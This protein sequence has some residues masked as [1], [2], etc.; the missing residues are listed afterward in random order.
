VAEGHARVRGGHVVIRSV[1]II[2]GCNVLWLR[3][4]QACVAGMF[5][6]KDF[7][8]FKQHL[9]DFLVQTKQFA[10]ANNAELFAEEVAQQQEVRAPPRVLPRGSGFR[11]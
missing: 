9:R 11:V 7:A 8:V 5:D 3:V 1:V 6:Y 2:R 4:M 10:D